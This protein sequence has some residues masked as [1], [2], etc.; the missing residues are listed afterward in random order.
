MRPPSHGS[1]RTGNRL[2]PPSETEESKKMKR[3]P[4]DSENTLERD[5]QA[6]LE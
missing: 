1:S 4:T 6:S 5:E 3:R 2:E